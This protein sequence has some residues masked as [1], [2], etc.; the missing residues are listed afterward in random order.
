MGIGPNPSLIKKSKMPAPTL[1]RFGLFNTEARVFH[2]RC[3]DQDFQIGVWLPFS[4]AVNQEQTYP[5][6]YVPDGEYAFPVAV[7]LLPTL[8]GSGEVPEMLVVG[9]AYHGI[10]GWEEFGVLRDR[11]FCTQPFQSPPHQS[12]HLQYTYFFQ[13]ELFPLIETEYRALPQ[14]RALFGF[15]SAG[16]FTLHMLF[17]QPGMFRRHIA[18]SCTWPG[19]G[20]YFLSCAQ[21]YAQ[22]PTQ[23]R[24]DLYLA[25]GR[26]D[27]GQ[28]PGFTQLTETL[29][30]GSYPNLRVCSQ[31]F[32][33]EG[34]S[35]GVIGNA[36]L[37]GL[38][39]VFR[40]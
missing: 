2:S 25:V 6:L 34:H 22:V 19:A 37:H 4:Y 5:V 15:S 29:T 38:K 23:P 28:L 10:T 27:E 31:V 40:N 26:L 33:E 12:R 16:F 17:T 30:N 39:T 18:A 20:E 35:A 9:I 8:I 13:E 32:E 14:D 11:D 21:Q 24:A 36:F 7:G 1:P 3:V